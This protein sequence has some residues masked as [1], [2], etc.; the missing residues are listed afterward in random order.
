M[1]GSKTGKEKPDFLESS[2]LIILNSSFVSSRVFKGFFTSDAELCSFQIGLPK[3]GLE[4]GVVSGGYWWGT[5]A[6]TWIFQVLSGWCF[7]IST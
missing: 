2:V 5:V 6:S 4:G 7:Q 1:F 3:M